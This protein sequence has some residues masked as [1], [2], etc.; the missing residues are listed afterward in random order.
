MIAPSFRDLDVSRNLVKSTPIL[1]PTPLHS[2]HIPCGSLNE[3]ALELPTY[4]LPTREK[5][6]LRID[7][8][9]VAVPIVEC[10]PPPIRF[11]STTTAILKF[12]IASASGWE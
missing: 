4:G 2:G 12:S 7:E 6:S 1:R 10:E 3:K 5:S 11:W 9:S 8:I